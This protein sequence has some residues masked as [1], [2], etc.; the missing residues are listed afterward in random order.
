VGIFLFL[1]LSITPSSSDYDYK[2]CSD[3][4][5]AIVLSK[6]DKKADWVT[7]PNIR[8]CPDVKISESR[9]KNAISFWE[10]LGY[11]FGSVVYENNMYNCLVPPPL[12]REIIIMLPDQQFNEKHLAST[13]LLTH[14]ITEEIV[15]AKIFITSKNSNRNRILEHEV[16]HAIGWAHYP[17]SG[18][19][20]NP[21]WK[22]GG[23]GSYGMRKDN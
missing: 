19:I 22:F 10:R 6:P 15:G 1:I 16:G 3:V 21:D 5:P 12:R 14:R 20:M 23:Y 7:P 13:R 11:N 2:Y 17:Q 18:H 4:Y 8:I 9:I